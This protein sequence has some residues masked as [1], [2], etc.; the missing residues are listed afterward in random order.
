MRK[1]EEVVEMRDMVKKHDIDHDLALAI[2]IT[3][4]WVLNETAETPISLLPEEES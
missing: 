2:Q 4:D 1:R 3:L